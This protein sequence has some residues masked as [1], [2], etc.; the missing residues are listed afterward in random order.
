MHTRTLMTVENFRRY[1]KDSTVKE[2][3]HRLG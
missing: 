2:M 3:L 1:W